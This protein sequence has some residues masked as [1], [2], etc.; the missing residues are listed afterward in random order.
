MENLQEKEKSTCSVIL[1]NFSYQI[2]YK[3]HGKNDFED[4]KK[5]KYLI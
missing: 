5:T 2:G 3:I 4:C 1:Y